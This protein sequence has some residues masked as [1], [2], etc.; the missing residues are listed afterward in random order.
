MRETVYVDGAYTAHRWG[1][2]A[3]PR[4]IIVHDPGN[5]RATPEN[6]LRFLRK[7][8]GRVSYDRLLWAHGQTA[9]CA[10]LA[11]LHE[12]TGHA[13]VATRIPG[14]SVTNGTV[15][16]LTVGISACTYG[17]P[18]L[19]GTPLFDALAEECVRVIYSAGMADAGV[20][21]AHREVNT[22]PG[23]RTDP[24]GV[25]MEQLRAAIATRLQGR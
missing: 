9:Y 17:R 22:V 20:V 12:W 3:A 18:T 1:R 4:W 24:R 2:T 8:A 23:R 5:D 19:P 21:L 11:P 25:D 16:R 6:V 14:T 7:N 10:V 13:G 15:N